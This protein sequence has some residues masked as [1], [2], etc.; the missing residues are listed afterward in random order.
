MSASCFMCDFFFSVCITD[1]PE[2]IKI[3]IHSVV[4]EKVNLKKGF[5]K[6]M[7]V[8]SANPYAAITCSSVMITWT[9]SIK[10]SL[11][12]QAEG[13]EELI[14]ITFCQSQYFLSIH[15]HLPLTKCHNTFSR[16][17][18][19]SKHIYFITSKSLPQFT[20]SSI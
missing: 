12:C 18:I 2:G 8:A 5:G 9:T 7:L 16:H 3:N 1:L 20:V 15:Y 19:H 17:K 6:Y 13:K 14:M 4:E 10:K 11:S